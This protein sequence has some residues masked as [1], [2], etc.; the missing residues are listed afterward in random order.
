[1]RGGAGVVD[2]CRDGG[3]RDDCED[4]C[5]DSAGSWRFVL[6]IIAADLGKRRT[7]T[8]GAAQPVKVDRVIGAI[9]YGEG[10]F[11]FN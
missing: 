1:M 2:Q 11:L 4:E 8:T 6:K 9:G 5:L 7:G 3:E 10:A